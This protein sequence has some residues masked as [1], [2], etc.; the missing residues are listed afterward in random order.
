MLSQ[1]GLHTADLEDLKLNFLTRMHTSTRYPSEDLPPVQLFDQ[2][3]GEECLE[4]AEKVI[5][6]TRTMK[7][8]DGEVKL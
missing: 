2:S 4:I 7:K 1:L 3:D 5:S 6:F 8:G